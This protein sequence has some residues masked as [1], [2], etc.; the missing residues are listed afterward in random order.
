MTKSDFVSALREHLS[1]LPEADIRRSTDYYSEIIEDRMED[2]VD[3]QQAVAALGPIDEIA[4]Q[5]LMDTPL[6]KLVKA[7]VKPSR[8]LRAWE[9]IF[10]IL[11]SPIWLSLLIAAVCVILAVYTVLWAVIVVFYAVVMSF[12]AAT[13][14]G[15]GGAFMFAIMGN[16]LSALGIF[17]VGLVCAGLAILLF[18]GVNALTVLFV[19]LSRIILHRIK[20]CFINKGDKQ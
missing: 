7:R 2:G 5:I 13:I 12:A 6:T 15:V 8:A 1:G 3:E 10:L 17:G 18:F 11:G 16:A 20:S 4:S 19:R 14:A 9:I